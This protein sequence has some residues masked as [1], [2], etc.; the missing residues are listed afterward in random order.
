MG[1]T[2][3]DKCNAMNIIGLLL[4]ILTAIT[5]LAS[6]CQKVTPEQLIKARN[7]LGYKSD[8]PKIQTNQESISGKWFGSCV[9]DV[10]KDEFF[11]QD[12]IEVVSNYIDFST[13]YFSDSNCQLKLFQQSLA[14]FFALEGEKLSVK[15]ESLSVMPEASIIAASFNRLDGFCGLKDWQIGNIKTFSDFKVCGYEKEF[16][17]K[18]ERYG[19]NELFLGERKLL[20]DQKN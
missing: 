3:D 17:S 6:G 16:S 11:R 14:G 2:S 13:E 15:Y 5:M 9:R 10:E 19:P 18:I 4:G 20:S 7:A 1:V 8:Q 12:K